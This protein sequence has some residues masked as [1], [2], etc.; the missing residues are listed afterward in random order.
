[1]GIIERGHTSV[2]GLALT[3]GHV[4]DYTAVFALKFAVIHVIQ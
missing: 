2:W 1:M 4:P 3:P